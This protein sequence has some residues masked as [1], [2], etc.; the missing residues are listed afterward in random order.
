[1]KNAEE[2]LTERTGLMLGVIAGNRYVLRQSIKFKKS[3]KKKINT[4]LFCT[5]ARIIVFR[6]LDKTRAIADNCNGVVRRKAVI[7]FC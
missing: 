3:K 2:N 1:M 4:C 5:R 7:R 6:N